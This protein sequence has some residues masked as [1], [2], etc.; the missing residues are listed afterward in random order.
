M[1]L[2]YPCTAMIKIHIPKALLLGWLCLNALPVFSN[3]IQVTNVTLTSRNTSAG[4][5]NVAN[6]TQV[7]FSLSW[8]NSWRVSVGP[9]NWDA[10]WVFV[11]FQVG[12]SDPVL[13]NVTSSGTT[14]TVS[15][16]ANLRVGMPVRVVSGTG[17]FANNTVISSIS[18]ATQFLVSAAPST[19]LSN[20]TITC[21]RIWEHAW[22]NNDGHTAPAGTIE[23]GLQTPG[24][25]F[26]ATTNPALGVFIHSNNNRNG[27]INYTNT[28]LRWNYG[29]NGVR[30]DALINVQVFAIEMVR[31]TQSAFFLGS[32]GMEGGSFTNG[33]WISGAPIP[34]QITSENAITI[35]QTAG[36][37][38]GTSTSGTSTIGAAGTLSADFPKGFRTFYCMKYEL[39]QGQYRDFLNT[40]SYSQ[41]A[42][43]TA[44][45]P[46]SAVGTG[47]LSSTNANRN[48]IDISTPG[49]AA[50]NTA[51]IYGCNLN[52][53]TSFNEADDGEWIACNYLSWMDGAAF[54][55]WAALR[56]MTEMEF[57][58]ACRGDQG[59]ISGE[60]AWGNTAIVQSSYTLGSP[61]TINEN[62]A[63][64]YSS[65]EG[66]TSYHTSDGTIN[67]PL[68]VGIFATAASSR[69]QAGAAYYGI[70]EMSGN[71][72]ERTVSV[73]NTEGRAFTGL[74]GDG[75][76]SINGHANTGNW[77][78]LTNS[79]VTGV[80]GAGLRGGNYTNTDPRVSNRSNAT[81]TT[82]EMNREATYGF[83]A[84]RTAQ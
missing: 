12:A 7:Q 40:L 80:T 74:H 51:A 28:Q 41:Q 35:G 27:D 38:W 25:N 54:A 30:D 60:Y 42:L 31:V 58:K 76:L 5:N 26:N 67:G 1:H 33:S 45:S 23:A 48:G 81:L 36:N 70:M 6:F 4:T 47:A 39:S 44:S 79:E 17:A 64:N 65:T 46:A 83:R 8:K 20:A 10:A 29:R 34:L 3:D 14:I 78:G 13:N 57:E 66:N 68:R 55:D 2:K 49:I 59:A 61:G 53:N 73:G 19:T 15:T 56:P 9:A 69:V 62:I 63:T 24:T 43:R 32:G 50:T 71:L 84:V 75:T 72:D 22:L 77:P 11:K 18:S 52:G 16:T 82:T 37:L 21:T